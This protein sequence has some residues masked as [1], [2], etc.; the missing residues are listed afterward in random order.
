MLR[1]RNVELSHEIQ[2]NH[3]EISELHRHLGQ[4]LPADNKDNAVEPM[5]IVQSVPD[6]QEDY[7]SLLEQVLKAHESMEILKESLL[8]QQDQMKKWIQVTNAAKEV[9][10]IRQDSLEPNVIPEAPTGPSRSLLQ[11][12]TTAT[13]SGNVKENGHDSRPTGNAKNSGETGSVD[14]RLCP[15]CEAEF[16]PDQVTHEEFET[17]VLDHFSCD[18]EQYETLRNQFDFVDDA[19]E[20]SR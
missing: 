15:M 14:K 2:H 5:S 6:D 1:D 12:S 4:V 16:P 17:H 7:D 11:T 19:G 3:S 18:E 8:E 13:P 20:M 9:S 10:S